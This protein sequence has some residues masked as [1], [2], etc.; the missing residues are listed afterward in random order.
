MRVEVDLVPEEAEEAV[1]PVTASAPEYTAAAAAAELV[2]RPPVRRALAV[3]L[4]S[5]QLHALAYQTL[6]GLAE[7]APEGTAAAL[8]EAVA[9]GA[10]QGF[11]AKDLMRGFSET[12]VPWLADTVAEMA[13]SERADEAAA[14]GDTEPG[15]V[16]F[17]LDGQD[18]TLRPGRSLVLAGEFLAVRL[19]MELFSKA[20]EAAADRVVR[21]S[22]VEKRLPL[23]RAESR[24]YTRVA[25]DNW[26]GCLRSRDGLAKVMLRY[27]MPKVDGPPALL[28]VDDLGKGIGKFG[29]LGFWTDVSAAEKRVSDWASKAGCSVLAGVVLPPDA[30]NPPKR[31]AEFCDT[32]GVSV[33]VDGD[34]SVLRVGVASPWEVALPKDVVDQYRQQFILR[35]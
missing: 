16:T 18:L 7:G 34:R 9:E 26:A 10:K 8:L 33:R 21:L 19:A 32:V 23:S 6:G 4:A 12:V 24:E 11:D 28:V 22:S 20:L 3:M 13:A 17:D 30:P 2:E 27:A 35:G 5:R 29:G 1:V 31:F 15:V 14:A 25:P